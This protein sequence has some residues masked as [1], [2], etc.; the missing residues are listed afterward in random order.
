MYY[1]LISEDNGPGIKI[2]PDF[3]E[4]LKECVSWN[5]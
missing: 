2:D 5:L 3:P 1:D 4:A